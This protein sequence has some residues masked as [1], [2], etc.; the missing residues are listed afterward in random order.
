M[1]KALN[2]L[3]AGILLRLRPT[4]DRPPSYWAQDNTLLAH[5]ER[6]KGPYDRTYAAYLNNIIDWPTQPGVKVVV[7]LMCVQSGKTQAVEVYFVWSVANS[8]RPARIVAQ[9]DKMAEGIA[10]DKIL[11][12]LKAS[13][14]TE[15]LMKRLPADAI[16]QTK[17]KIP[18]MTVDISGTGENKL[19]SNTKGII[20]GDEMWKWEAG[21]FNR[22]IKRIDAGVDTRF[23][24]ASQCGKQI[25]VGEDGEPLFDDVV[26][27]FRQGTMHEREVPCHG[28]GE[29]FSL[30][31]EHMRCGDLAL[32]DVVGPKG[33]DFQHANKRWDLG[34][35]TP[36][37]HCVC[38]HCGHQ[39]FP[40]ATKDERETFVRQWQN[41]GRY[42]QK[43]PTPRTG[44]ITARG[45]SVWN[46]WWKDWPEMAEEYFYAIAARN[47]GD[48]SLL[49]DWRMQ[50][51]AKP[52][53]FEDEEIPI[54]TERKASG[55]KQGDY[56]P[57]PNEP[58]PL[59]V[60]DTGT[61]IEAKRML[62]GD[63][64]IDRTEAIVLA[65]AEDGSARI[66]LETKVPH[67]A[68]ARGQDNAIVF[69]GVRELQLAYGIADKF[70][71]IDVGEELRGTVAAAASK[72]GW[73]G[74]RGAKT[75]QEWISEI[76]GKKISK[77]F[78]PTQAGFDPVSKRRFRIYEW[79]NK[80]YKDWMARIVEGQGLIWEFPDDASQEFW[81]SLHSERKGKNG[82]WYKFGRRPNHKWD[83]LCMGLSLGTISRTIKLVEKEDEEPAEPA[84]T[85]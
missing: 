79:S 24:G 26:E 69:G 63:V 33:K 40:G 29:F 64:Q 66:L 35:V 71:G 58:A 55:Y 65:L 82:V 44:F 76:S 39:H 83:C 46:V 22:L 34:K 25:G 19:H 41:K 3:A 13:P 59:W 8:P 42:D 68:V 85:D 45:G 20:I 9:S 52:W 36:A 23:V 30:E 1:R 28:C 60:S 4:D 51:E 67:R 18:G 74:L 62:I 43:N 81:D 53:L 48:I 11:Q 80:F 5:S 72:W 73:T 77:P 75:R 17:W 84:S 50:R 14:A 2:S 70:V 56:K 37:L 27:I 16:A 38:P 10:E 78:S 32:E 12:T 57:K 54:L 7:F 47:R 49:R 61:V 6:S 21:V 15:A 31:T